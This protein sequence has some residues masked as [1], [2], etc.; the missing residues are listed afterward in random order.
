MRPLPRRRY[1]QVGVPIV[2]A[3][4]VILP[5]WLS[6]ARCSVSLDG[7]ASLPCVASTAGALPALSGPTLSG[8][9]FD[10]RGLRGHVTVVNFWNPDCGP[11]RREAPALQRA[12]SALHTKGVG[13]VGAMF[14]G[15][16]WPDDRE[17]ARA[18]VARYGLAY[19]IVVDEGSTIARGAVIPGIPVTIVSDASG[20]MRYRIVGPV[21][22]G[23][24]E[25]LVAK[26]GG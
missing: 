11:C 18:F 6:H 15:G 26:L 1:F 4:A 12:W 9:A 22:D 7:G 21:R 10:P 5:L 24:I 20:V 13:F 17:A 8:A 3:A 14:V 23:Q 2:V 25:G 19:P 16:G